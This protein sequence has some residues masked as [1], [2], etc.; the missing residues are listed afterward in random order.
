[1]QKRTPFK[2]AAIL[3]ELSSFLRNEIAVHLVNDT[4][5]HVPMFRF[6]VTKDP[7]FITK[8]LVLLKA[9]WGRLRAPHSSP[10]FYCLPQRR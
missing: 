9:R 3:D 5:Y 4:V 10:A 1:M 8:L 6:I 7:Y 2:E